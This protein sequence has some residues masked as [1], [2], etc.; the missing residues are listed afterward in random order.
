MNPAKTQLF[1]PKGDSLLI[2][3]KA[4][5]C[6]EPPTEAPTEPPTEP[7]TEAPTVPPTESPT[8]APTES[9]TDEPNE[10]TCDYNKSPGTCRGYGDPHYKTFDKLKY[11]FYGPCQ[12]IFSRVKEDSVSECLPFYEVEVRQEAVWNKDPDV[13]MIEEVW[14]R[15][16]PDIE[17]HIMITDSPKA[18]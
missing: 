8:E 9:P 3:N 6:S 15:F 7:P 5:T 14:F 13:T 10:C 16:E 4:T 12:Y 18:A 17:I 1:L 11:G 2:Q